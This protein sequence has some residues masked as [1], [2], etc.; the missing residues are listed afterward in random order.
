MLAEGTGTGVADRDVK[1]ARP[2]SRLPPPRCPGTPRCRGG[3]AAPARPESAAQTSGDEISV[4]G[5]AVSP[6]GARRNAAPEYRPIA[7]VPQSY[8]IWPH[9]KLPTTCPAG[10]RSTVQGGR[11]PADATAVLSAGVRR[12]RRHPQPGWQRGGSADGYRVAAMRV[13]RPRGPGETRIRAL[14]AERVLFPPTTIAGS[15][16]RSVAFDRKILRRADPLPG[17]SGSAVPRT[18]K[19]VG[20][21]GWGRARVPD[22]F[23][24]VPVRVGR[25]GRTVLRAGVRLDGD[26]VR[27]RLRRRPGSRSHARVP[28][29]RGRTAGRAPGGDAHRRPRARA[30]GRRERGRRHHSRAP[31]PSRAGGASTSGSPVAGQ[32]AVWGSTT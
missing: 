24:R 30:A 12:H 16:S 10:G 32:L 18:A 6:A 14:R 5:K 21:A 19:I 9:P 20:G 23:R 7:T 26:A 13:V 27:P 8:G 22:R 2:A 29:G 1:G 31:S 25:R 3:P 11:Q 28:S 4:L 15:A 17:S